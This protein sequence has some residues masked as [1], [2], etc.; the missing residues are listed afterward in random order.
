MPREFWVG[1]KVTIMP[2][3]EDLPLILSM[4]RHV[5]VSASEIRGDRGAFVQVELDSTSDDN[6]F[7]M[8]PV[9]RLEHGWVD[10]RSL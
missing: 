1:D 8:V 9:G 2:P 5:R 3:Y 4:Q 6:R 7:H 10:V